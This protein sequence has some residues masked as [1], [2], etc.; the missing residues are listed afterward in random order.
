MDT[1]PNDTPTPEGDADTVDTSALIAGKYKTQ[2]DLVAAY[3]ESQKKLHEQAAELAKQKSASETPA[4]NE[5]P[6]DIETLRSLG[7]AFK[8]DLTLEKAEADLLKERPDAQSRLNVV[9]AL[10][11]TE[12][13]AGKSLSEI[14]DAVRNTMPTKQVPVRVRMGMP[15]Q[16][17]M[18]KSLD[19]M[20]DAE[21]KAKR[22]EQRGKGST[23]KERKL[24]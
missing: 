10:A 23:L 14:D 11:Q 1:T 2:D 13:F 7:V 9:K 24:G 15:V 22:D 16:E 21:F 12:E 6:L 3:K 18:E 19:E 17:R 5:Q 8:D 4:K 20:T